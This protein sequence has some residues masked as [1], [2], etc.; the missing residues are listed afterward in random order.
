MPTT[1]GGTN[2]GKNRALLFQQLPSWREDEGFDSLTD[3]ECDDDRPDAEGNDGRPLCSDFEP[4]S[5]LARARIEAIAAARGRLASFNYDEHG[6]PAEEPRPE[7][8]IGGMEPGPRRKLRKYE[9]T[10]ESPLDPEDSDAPVAPGSEDGDDDDA[11]RPRP[12]RKR[13]PNTPKRGTPAKR[14]R[15]QAAA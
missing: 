13:A 12:V 3:S 15:G 10:Y 6:Q 1:R 5:A 7:A 9:L 8:L 14:G 4:V 11:D 2:R